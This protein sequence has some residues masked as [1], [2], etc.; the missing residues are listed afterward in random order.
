M[1]NYDLD[2]CCL[3]LLGFHFFFENPYPGGVSQFFP[4]NNTSNNDCNVVSLLQGRT[5]PRRFNYFGKPSCSCVYLTYCKNINPTRE[6]VCRW[7]WKCSLEKT[8]QE[9]GIREFSERV[10]GIDVCHRNGIAYIYTHGMHIHISWKWSRRNCNEIAKSAVTPV[11]HFATLQIPAS[12][13]RTWA[14]CLATVMHVCIHGMD[15]C[16]RYDSDFFVLHNY[17]NLTIYKLYGVGKIRYSTIWTI[18]TSYVNV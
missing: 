9:L 7:I 10:P 4:C 16:G 11:I 2:F 5:P 1:H 17:H 12:A 3:Y 13:E 14:E 8:P 15:W 6:P 18:R